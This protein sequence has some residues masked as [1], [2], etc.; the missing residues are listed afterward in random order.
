MRVRC[1]TR[2]RKWT[3]LR[4]T[5]QPRR[6]MQIVLCF[7]GISVDA[8]ASYPA[9]RHRMAI[10]ICDPLLARNAQCR[11]VALQFRRARSKRLSCIVLRHAHGITRFARPLRAA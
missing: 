9:P 11:N 10:D 8:G 7:M 4:P 3:A 2:T 1:R 6:S 5:R